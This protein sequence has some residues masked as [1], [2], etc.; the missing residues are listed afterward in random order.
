M[1]VLTPVRLHRGF[2]EVVER[3][4]RA[5]R[6]QHDEAADEL[7][8]FIEAEA[9]QPETVRRLWNQLW[10]DG[11]CATNLETEGIEAEFRRLLDAAAATLSFLREWA[12][13]FEAS[14]G[15][16]TKNADLL[17]R[18]WQALVE[19]RTKILDDLAWIN[20]P[21]PGL[22][23]EQVK[24]IMADRGPGENVEDIIREL[25]GDVRPDRPETD[26]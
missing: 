24:E 10:V 9:H 6:S 3:E 18:T 22:T 8:A 7:D 21:L 19:L 1:T 16:K 5:V 25:Q 23:D 14:T 15:R 12:Q 26:R 17:E 20:A 11:T 2:A 4:A 13:Q